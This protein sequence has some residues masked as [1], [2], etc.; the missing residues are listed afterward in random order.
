MSTA[1]ELDLSVVIPAY[2]G[3]E[4]LDRCLAA[5]ER[6]LAASVPPLRAEI[7]VADDATPGGLPDPLVRAHPQVR[8]VG[9]GSER[10][11]RGQC[12]PR[13]GGVARARSVSPE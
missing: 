2:G 4:Q 7:V 5:V 10:R 3:A 8:F 11:I 9:G 1:E 12:E 6:E 13:C